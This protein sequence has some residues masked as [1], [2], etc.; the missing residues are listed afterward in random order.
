MYY[1]VD[2]GQSQHFTQVFELAEKAG[3]LYRGD[4]TAEKLDNGK[5]ASTQKHHCLL[6]HIEFGVILG[7]TGKRFRSRFGFL[8]KERPHT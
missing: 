4:K 1:V 3:W 7:P 2:A 6:R 8:K 5:T